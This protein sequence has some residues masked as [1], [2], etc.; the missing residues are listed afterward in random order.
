[1][2]MLIVVLIGQVSVY[3]A[4]SSEYHGVTYVFV[5]NNINIVI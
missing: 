1:M 3:W 2:K 5:K 4:T